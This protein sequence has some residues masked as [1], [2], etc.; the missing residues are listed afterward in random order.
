MGIGSVAA[1]AAL[2][3]VKS[4]DFSGMLETKHWSE[5]VDKV[6]S[7]VHICVF[8]GG[9]FLTAVASSGLLGPFGLIIGVAGLVSGGVGLSSSVV[10]IYYIR[11]F[12]EA[13]S[14]RDAVE[15]NA[16]VQKQLDGS[17]AK[18]ESLQDD[19]SSTTDMLSK[20]N[21][22]LKAI[23]VSL[24]EKTK[25]LE[26]KTERL[27][28]VKDDVVALQEKEQESLQALIEARDEAKENIK[29]VNAV[30]EQLQESEAR[31]RENLSQLKSIREDLDKKN[32]Q[33]EDLQKKSQEAQRKMKDMQANF[34]KEFQEFQESFNKV[35][36]AL[37]SFMETKLQTVLE[38]EFFRKID[39]DMKEVLANMGFMVNFVE[40]G[41]TRNCVIGTERPEL[42]RDGKGVSGVFSVDIS[43]EKLTR[44]KEF[45]VAAKE[46][47]DGLRDLTSALKM[48]DMQMSM[49]EVRKAADKI[50][51]VNGVVAAKS[52]A[53]RLQRKARVL[54]AAKK[55]KHGT[56]V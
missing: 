23:T 13:G 51:G 54:V 10:S 12:S 35:K 48:E 19:L 24:Q 22:E 9:C 39:V 42:V 5:N 49:T 26:G 29:E 44:L 2:S 45:I 37:N 1:S 47:S 11:E 30:T 38:H 15:R 4:I 52:V 6:A 25:E 41:M 20:S 8:A 3:S 17:L 18:V 46:I 14:I 32:A 16:E 56:N 33:A 28:S 21:D 36:A 55:V 27:A 43:D 50:L 34:H 53:K 40:D 31:Q 7:L